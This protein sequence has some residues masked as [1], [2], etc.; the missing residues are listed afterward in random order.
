MKEH[1][2]LNQ[3][4]SIILNLYN[5]K[6]FD[7]VVIKGKILIKKY[8]KQNI[9]YNIV[10][11]SLSSLNKND[12]AIKLLNLALN[13][14]INDI[15]VLNNI[16]LIQSKIGNFNLA[17]EYLEKALTLKNDFV[18]AL[19][20]I[21]NIDLKQNKVKDAEKKLLKALAASKSKQ[22]DEIINISLAQ[23][24]QQ[25]GEFN[26]SLNYFKNVNKINPANCI[27]DKGISTIHRYQSKNDEHITSMKKKLEF[28]KDKE[29]LSALNF[30]IGKAYDDIGE[31]KTSFKY[32]K[33]GNKI[34]NSLLR[35]NIEEDKIF[36]S[37]LKKFF[38]GDVGSNKI[39]C[40]KKFIFIIGMPRSG[41]TLVEQIISSHRNVFGAGELNYLSESLQ[42]I[43]KNEKEFLFSLYSLLEVK[44]L[45][46][47]Q[48]DY[49][50][51]TDLLVRKEDFLI[52]KAPLNFRWV[53]FIR[54]IFPNS[55]IIH[56]KR[57]PMD[58]CFSNYKNSFAGKSLPFTYDLKNL[59]IFYNLYE[60]LM[61]FW[62]SKYP[63]DI[64]NLDYENL[65]NNQEIETR[66]LINYCSLDWDK[67]CLL[68]HKNKKLVATAS[69]SQVRNPL[70]KNSINKWQKYSEELEELYKFI[71]NTKRAYS[72]S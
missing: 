42:K 40:K 61:N 11:L 64:Y 68:P 25:A 22:S 59:A 27:A 50:K 28:V 18:D 41:T 17:R 14:N 21:S 38:S 46:T 47:I 29:H 15:N 4:L 30:A 35:Y 63:K 67:N 23:L 31:F 2:F 49:I 24:N 26:K 60:D 44:D 51:K 57:E 45:Q 7:E 43:I 16:G 48:Q 70:Y 10:A 58:I 13:N 36:F 20:N 53:G 72:L 6:I 3:Q 19:I 1:Q 5:S 55:K 54:N 8:P 33:E 32:I 52:D 69:L 65:V 66:N 34:F 37:K 71:K 62:N 12:E 39:S 56:C 9:F